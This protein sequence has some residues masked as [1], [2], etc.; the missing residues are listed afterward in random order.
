MRARSCAWLVGIIAMLCVAMGFCEDEGEDVK[1]RGKY[2]FTEVTGEL[3][4]PQL[5]CEFLVKDGYPALRILRKI[6]KTTIGVKMY[7]TL[8]RTFV[9]GNAGDVGSYTYRVLTNEHW[10]GEEVVTEEFRDGGVLANAQVSVN[11]IPMVT[12]DDGIVLDTPGEGPGLLDFFDDMDKVR[13]EITVAANG[14]LPVLFTVFRS[15][16]QRPP[17]DEKLI[18]EPLSQEI[19]YAYGLDFVKGKTE[20]ERKRLEVKVEAIGSIHPGVSYSVKVT[21]VNHG[22]KPTNCLAARCFSRE[23]WAHGKWFYF[24][25]VQPGQEISFK[26]HFMADELSLTDTCFFEVRFKDSWGTLPSLARFIAGNNP[27]S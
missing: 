4:E 3:E 21:V 25:A 6:K 1:C 18:Q 9:S 14:M 8:L 23:P 17:H 20:P 19:L 11:K 22:D 13:C 10:K 5:A 2:L 15:M 16:P 12:D 27:V 26:R 24:G 7:E